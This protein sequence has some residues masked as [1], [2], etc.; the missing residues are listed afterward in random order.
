MRDMG[1]PTEKH[2]PEAPAWIGGNMPQEMK[3]IVPPPY[4]IPEKSGERRNTLAAGQDA[5][6][7]YAVCVALF[8]SCRRV[9]CVCAD[10]GPGTRIERNR[11][12]RDALRFPSPP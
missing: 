5:A 8:F 9:P 4:R 1:H 6:A 11:G 3:G 10:C 7:D 12:S 2:P